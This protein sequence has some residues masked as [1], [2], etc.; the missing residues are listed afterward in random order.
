MKRWAAILAVLF[1]LPLAAAPTIRLLTIKPDGNAGF[2][3]FV[4]V[5][6][7]VF[8]I[9]IDPSGASHPERAARVFVSEGVLGVE[10]TGAG[11][12]TSRTDPAGI[13]WLQ[14]LAANY[15][16]LAPQRAFGPEQPIPIA[17]S[18]DFCGIFR[19]IKRTL[20]LVDTMGDTL[21]EVSINRNPLRMIA[22][23]DAI[24]VLWQSRT[25]D[26]A[27]WQLLLAFVDRAGH[28]S[29]PAPIATRRDGFSPTVVPHP[30]GV[31]VFW[32]DE[33]QVAAAVVRFDGTIAAQATYAAPDLSVGSI[34]A[35]S[36]GGQ[37][38][39][40]LGTVLQ[41]ACAPHPSFCPPARYAAYAMRLSESLA[42][43]EPLVR[44][45]PEALS[46]NIDL[47]GASGD[48]VFARWDATYTPLPPN[49]FNP[50]EPWKAVWQSFVLRIPFTGPIDP[51]TSVPF[52]GL[53]PTGHRRSATH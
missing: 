20:L 43:L 7:T 34:S 27:P 45:A 50:F 13:G 42:V 19:T 51:S 36:A 47:I 29:T 9:P 53:I 35:V 33:Q 37:I 3:A 14:P 18:D 11:Y 1:A 26:D 25:A 39:L 24:V 17:C 16:P 31:A 32:P 15:A 40:G 8:T 5:G 12:L 23:G 30:L 22:V 38:A 10:S 48:A 2:T 44:L 41:Y 28:I 21:I 6:N 49:P 52:N 4:A 46:S